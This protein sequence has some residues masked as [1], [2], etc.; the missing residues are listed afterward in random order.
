MANADLK[1]HGNRPEIVDIKKN[2][3]KQMPKP[4]KAAKKVKAPQSIMKSPRKGAFLA[5]T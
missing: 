5:A 1:A 3:L 2:I 4:K